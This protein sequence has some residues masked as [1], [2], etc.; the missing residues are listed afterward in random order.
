SQ[1]RGTSRMLQSGGKQISAQQ[2]TSSRCA[3]FVLGVA[4]AQSPLQ[5]RKRNAAIC[6]DTSPL[7]QR[8]RN[9]TTCQ[10]T[11]PPAAAQDF[12]S[13]KIASA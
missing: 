11:F 1:P 12:A 5:Q 10:D 8:T 2:L 9:V 3:F 7:R 4:D 13:S 6:Q